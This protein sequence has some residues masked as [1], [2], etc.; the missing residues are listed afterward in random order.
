MNYDIYKNSIGKNLLC[1]MMPYDNIYLGIRS[2][3]S[4][5][6]AGNGCTGLST[7]ESDFVKKMSLPVFH[8]YF[9]ITPENEGLGRLSL[10]ERDVPIDIEENVLPIEIPVAD[11]TAIS[12]TNEILNNLES[13]S[14]V[15][16]EFVENNPHGIL[17]D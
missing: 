8:K 12:R 4:S 7:E 16:R 3:I 14:R 6:D 11:I 2:P 13:S 5:C 9:I 10:G 15:K 17:G 1:R